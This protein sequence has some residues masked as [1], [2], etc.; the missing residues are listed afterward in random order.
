[1]AEVDVR[2]TPGWAV[3][4]YLEQMGARAQPDGRWQAGGWAAT[5]WEGTHHAYGTLYVPRVVITFT[6]DPEQAEAAARKMKL[7]AMRVGG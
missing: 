5:L 2:G 3:R 4:N 7:L 1:M 6:G